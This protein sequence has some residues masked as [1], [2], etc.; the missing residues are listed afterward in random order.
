MTGT[1]A[2]HTCPEN[3]YNPDPGATAFANCKTYPKGAVTIGTGMT[4]IDN[5]TCP[6]RTYIT[7]ESGGNT[8]CRTCPKGAEC[9]DRT[10]GCGLRNG[11]NCPLVDTWERHV[12]TNE[13]ILVK[14]PIGYKLE[15]ASG[16]D[17]RECQK[18]RE[19]FYVQDSNNPDDQCRKCPSSA[20]CINGAPPIFQV[21]TVKGQ[22]ELSGLPE[23]GGEQ[24]VLEALAR[25][26]GVDPS[27][28]V[29]PDQARRRRRRAAS[30]RMIVFEIVGDA[31]TAA[32]VAANLQNDDVISQLSSNLLS[33]YPNITVA[34]FGEVS[35]DE[36]SASA[37]EEWGIFDGIYYL[38][39]CPPGHLLINTTVELSV[40]KECETG[41]YSFSYADGCNAM[42][43]TCDMRECTVCP[44][45]VTCSRGIEAQ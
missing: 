45:G 35:P 6:I 39:K 3:T 42:T 18:C 26:L 2:C 36:S 41:K 20:T 15:N 43:Q 8:A 23:T 5:C 1:H 27:Y 21:T 14:C 16:H 33:T 40:R 30:S 10:Q 12:T 25:A 28:I 19:G 13:Y 44:A 9:E 22:I 34:V 32:S 4:S 24:A 29:L 37:G 31:S 11:A 38:R 7:E 17:N